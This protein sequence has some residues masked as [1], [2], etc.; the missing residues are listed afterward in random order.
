MRKSL[1]TKRLEHPAT[2]GNEIPLL[3]IV[4]FFFNKLELF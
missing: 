1:S 4:I 2:S 3:P